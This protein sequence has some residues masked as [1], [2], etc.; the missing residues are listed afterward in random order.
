MVMSGILLIIVGMLQIVV[1][2][3]VGFFGLCE[4]QIIYCCR[5]QSSLQWGKYVFVPLV[6]YEIW[7]LV[8]K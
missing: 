5:R 2:V 7:L 1:V 4:A 6:N 8:E 3:V